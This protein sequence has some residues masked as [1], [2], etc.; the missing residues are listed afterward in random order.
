MGRNTL[1]NSVGSFI[2]L[3]CQ[4]LLSILVI[5]LGSYEDGGV[6]NLCMSITNIMFTMATFGVRSFMVSDRNEKYSHWRSNCRYDAGYSAEVRATRLYLLLVY[7][8]WYC[9]SCFF[10]DHSD[11]IARHHG[12]HSCHERKLLCNRYVLRLENLPETLSI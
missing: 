2:Y 7:Y 3:I 12:S 10:F 8:A 5:K 4:F 9:C 11:H 6:L 1:Y